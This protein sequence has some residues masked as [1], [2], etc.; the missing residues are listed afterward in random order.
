MPLG[1]VARRRQPPAVAREV[2]AQRRST[3]SAAEPEQRLRRRR[4]SAPATSSSAV[5]DDQRRDPPQDLPAELAVLPAD[6][7]EHEDVHQ[8]HREVADREDRGPVQA[9]RPVV[10]RLGDRD[11]DD[12]HAAHRGEHRDPDDAL[13][14]AGDVAQPRVARPAPPQHAEHQHAAEHV[15]DRRVL[16]HQV[17]DLGEREHEHQVEEQLQR[18]DDGAFA[19]RLHPR[20]PGGRHAW[21]VPSSPPPGKL[22]AAVRCDPAGESSFRR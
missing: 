13:V 14:G 2:G 11:R 4:W 12:E 19:R 21:I 20:A 5:R 17:G 6:D 8:P 3:T 16:G 9:A 7:P 10:E 18:G 22:G 15:P 1:E